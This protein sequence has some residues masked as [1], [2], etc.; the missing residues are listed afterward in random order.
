MSVVLLHWLRN[1]GKPMTEKTEAARLADELQYKAQRGLDPWQSELEQAAAELRRLEVENASLR[2][3][4]Y[5]QPA[6]EPVAL[7]VYW[8]IAPMRKHSV[9]FERETA[10]QAAQEIKS[11][12]TE[13]RPLYATPRPES[14]PVVLMQAYRTSA[15]Y[16]VG[17]KDGQKAATLQPASEFVALTGKQRA[18]LAQA[19]AMLEDY[20]VINRRM[21]NG[22]FSDGA[23][24]SAHEIKLLLAASPTQARPQPLTQIQITAEIIRL[25]AEIETL[26]DA[27]TPGFRDGVRF[28]ESFHGIAAT[29]S[30][31][32]AERSSVVEPVRNCRHCGGPDDVI[33]TGQ[34]RA[35]KGTP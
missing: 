13:I 32:T 14:E 22:S 25:T 21:G 23:I 1:Q 18:Y 5:T 26:E 7:A 16:D 2:S 19:W 10:E 33:C 35:S 34:C 9:H 20:S 30:A 6:N 29:P 4:L 8:G 15:A 28:A 27:P 3:A 17:F 31:P 11:N 24:A 12:N